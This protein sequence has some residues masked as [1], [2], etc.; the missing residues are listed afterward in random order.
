MNNLPYKRKSV[1]TNENVDLAG[2]VIEL[3]GEKKVAYNSPALYKHFLNRCKVGD[4]ISTTI[5]N[6]RPKR[7]TV[8]NNYYHLYLSLISLSSGHSHDDLHIWVKGKFLSTG[9]TEVFGDKIR[10]VKSTTRLNI[11]EFAEMLER[12][13]H[14]TGIPL[15]PTEIFEQALTTS[16]AIEFK[17][18]QKEVYA[19]LQCSKLS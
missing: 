4:Y 10:K 16:E 13:Q 9:I 6:K 18:K 17:R 2:K 19:K 11:S 1:P 3:N 8:Q 12:I 14:A 5:T 7:S 15:P